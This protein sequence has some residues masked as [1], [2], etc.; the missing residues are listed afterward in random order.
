M[1]HPS[2]AGQDRAALKSLR[3]IGVGSPFGAD[4][5]G[6]ELATALGR[7]RALVSV[8]GPRLSVQCSDRPGA[9]LLEYVAGVEFAIILDA[10]T[11]GLPPYSIRCF[12]VDELLDDGPLLSSH[13]MGVASALA[14]GRALAILP[15]SLFVLGVEVEKE[16]CPP[17]R[18]ASLAAECGR[19]ILALAE[20]AAAPSDI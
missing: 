15:A 3:L 17:W 18:M 5:L 8:F 9:A 20:A 7:E 13:G 1:R 10:M 11:A 6:W 16:A 2:P 14:L 12:S 19:L 4:S